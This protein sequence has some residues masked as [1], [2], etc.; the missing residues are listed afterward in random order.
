MPIGLSGE[1]G[2]NGYTSG[3]EHLEALKLEDEE[4]HLWKHC[5]VEHGLVK[6]EFSIKVMGRVYS[7]LVRQFNEAVRV[8]RSAAE[9]VQNRKAEFH[10]YSLVRVVDVSGLNEEK[11][12]GPDPS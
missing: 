8:E 1:T 2:R 5:F 4:I 10:K 6:T 7:C 12:E 11:G 3:K 9:Y